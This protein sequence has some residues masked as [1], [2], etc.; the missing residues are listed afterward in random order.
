MKKLIPLLFTEFAMSK[1]LYGTFSILI[2]SLITMSHAFTQNAFTYNTVGNDDLV[3]GELCPPCTIGVKG[4]DPKLECIPIVPDYNTWARI[5][6][7][8]RIPLGDLMYDVRFR[9]HFDGYGF[10]TG[11]LDKFEGCFK[12][13]GGCEYCVYTGYV[14]FPNTICMGNQSSEQ[15]INFSSR[16]YLLNNVIMNKDNLVY[17]DGC[18]QIQQVE[19]YD[20]KQGRFTICCFPG[21]KKSEDR[22]AKYDK[23]ELIYPNP[24]DD[25]IQ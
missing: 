25:Y 11:Y 21:D 2:F 22:S 3:V 17:K 10:T 24:F 4:D 18:D 15:I 9:L 19:P 7:K 6:F 20:V 23:Q 16:W 14:P 1:K 5:T 8:S 12:D 13:A